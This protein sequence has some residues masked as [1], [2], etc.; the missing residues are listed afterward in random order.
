[1]DVT[2]GPVPRGHP[3]RHRCA[4]R[5]GAGTGQAVAGAAPARAARSG[6]SSTES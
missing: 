3:V 6:G 4:V 1:M 2:T 5:P